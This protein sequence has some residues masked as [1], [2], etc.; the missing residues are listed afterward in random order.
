L[1]RYSFYCFLSICWD[2]WAM[3]IAY[4]ITMSWYAI[5]TPLVLQLHLV[6]F[7]LA[8]ICI[9]WP[10]EDVCVGFLCLRHVMLT[11]LLSLTD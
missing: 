2:I 6:H 5:F 3:V 10:L 1:S 9:W 8:D 11:S 7:A 4:T